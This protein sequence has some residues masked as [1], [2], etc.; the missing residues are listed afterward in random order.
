MRSLLYRIFIAN[1]RRKLLALASAIVIWFLVNNSITVTKTFPGV[2][3][4][5]I[6]LPEDKTI[7]GLQ[8]NGLLSRRIPVT[9]T[10][11]SNVLE[12]ASASD[13]EIVIDAYNKGDRWTTEISKR[14]LISLN[15]D[16]DLAYAV[17][18]VAPAE[19]TIQ[20]S[21]LVTA[22]IPVIIASP[23][24]E[25]PQGYQYLDVWPQRLYQTISGPK[26]Q[27]DD[28]KAKGL[29]LTLDLG[30]VTKEELDALHSKRRAYPEDEVRYFVPANWKRIIIPF[31]GDKTIPINDPDAAF[32]H[33]D[34]LKQ[35][36]LPLKY[37][38]PVQVYY[39]SQSSDT[40]NPLTAPLLEGHA[41]KVE[42]GLYLLNLKIY[43]EDVSRFFLDTVSDFIAITIVAAPHTAGKP[44]A[45]SVEFVDP[46]A[47]EEA[48]ILLSMAN[49]SSESGQ[50]LNPKARE[51]LL[52]ERF[53]SYIRE[54]TIV[55]EN[56]LPLELDCELTERG[57]TVQTSQPS[58]ANIA[59]R[60]RPVAFDGDG[61]RTIEN[62]SLGEEPNN[63]NVERAAL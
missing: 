6:H 15:P 36:L 26:P 20:L 48:F 54:F 43:T 41:V 61:N 3:I 46:S 19:V 18:E 58:I 1:W 10:G 44:L 29:R 4:R 22:K 34:F 47:L 51:E 60:Y 12:R 50:E 57:I 40:V 13:F 37:P 45:W 49:L 14:N 7:E 31:L 38:L 55:T 59:K 63:L 24:G 27:I 11:R 39:P 25:P 42:R 21:P 35:E 30:K 23:V 16:I 2:P 17:T 52:R 8:P 28:L 56:G 9:I 33:I 5:V 53:R 32:L 62:W